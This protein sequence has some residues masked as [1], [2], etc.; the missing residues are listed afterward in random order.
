MGVIKSAIK[1][2]HIPAVIW[3]APASKI[4]LYLHG[5]NGSKEEAAGLA[6]ILCRSGFQILS[7]DLPEHGERQEGPSDFAPWDVVPELNFIMDFI[8]SQWIEVSLYANSIGAW[9]GMQ[10]FRDEPL[11]NCLFV[12]PVIDMKQMIQNMMRRANV[13]EKQLQNEKTIITSFGQTLSWNYWRYAVEHPVIK[14]NVPTKILYGE[15]DGMTDFDVVRQFADKFHCKLTVMENAGH[16]FH[17]EQE[18]DFLERWV[19]ANSFIP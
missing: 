19:M 4:Y 13:T 11:Q 1:I 10:S 12:S 6:D 17:T 3:G 2:G 16:W 7:I 15:K 5:Q 18:L 9:F 14:W 8:K